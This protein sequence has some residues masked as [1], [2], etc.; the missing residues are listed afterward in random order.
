MKEHERLALAALMDGEL[1]G[2][3]AETDRLI[4]HPVHGFGEIR[5]Q[6]R[7]AS[8]QRGRQKYGNRKNRAAQTHLFPTSP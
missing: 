4:G 7:G 8:G 2:L 5:H 1:D 6:R 3:I